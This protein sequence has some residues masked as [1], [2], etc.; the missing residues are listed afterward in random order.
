MWSPVLRRCLRQFYASIRGFQKN[1][2]VRVKTYSRIWLEALESRLA[3]AGGLSNNQQLLQ[4]YGQMPISFEANAGQTN[5]QV[6]YLAHGS[7]Y[8]VFL[9]PTGA[10]LSLEKDAAVTPIASPSYVKQGVADPATPLPSVTGVALAMTLVGANPGVSVTGLDQLS[11]TS[12]YFIGNGLSQWHTNIAN[13]G[14]VAY[15]DVYPGVNLVYYGNQQQLEYDFVVASGA[16]PSSIRLDFQGAD[17]VSLDDRGNLVLATASGDVVEHTP[18]VY[19]EVGG[20]RQ[21]IAGKFVLLGQGEV[22]FQVGT[23]D[24]NLPLTIDPVLSYSTYLGGS[25]GDTGESIAVDSSGNA[26]IAGYANSTNFPTTAGAFQTSLDS[27]SDAFV[28]KLNA[29]GTALIYSTYLGGS[30]ADVANGIAVDDSGNAY[31]AGYT[32]STNFPTTVGAFQ[33][34]LGGNNDAFVTKLDA[35][36]TALIYSTYLGGNNN[37]SAI[38]IAVDGSGNAYIGGLTSSTNFPT[39]VGAF[40]TSLGGSGN[41][42]AFVTKL[43]ATGAALIY[44][45]Y[46]GGSG[47]DAAYGIAVDSSGNSYVAGSTASTNFPTT[48][49]A[50]QTSLGGNNDAFVTKLDASGTA[51]IYSTYLGG[52]NNDVA[53][54]IAVDGSGNAFVT[55]Y[56]ESTNFPTT[57]GAFQTSLGG[58][59]NYNA[60][61]TKLDATG[62]ALSYSTY[63]GGSGNDGAYGIAVDS[64]GN[65]YIAG[66]VGS[67]N[68]PT[69]TGAFQTS[70]GGSSNVNAFVTKLN[71]TGTAL[72]YSTYLGGNGNDGAYGIAVDSSGNSYVTGEAGSAKF[73]ITTGAYQTMGANDAFVAKFSFAPVATQLA[74]GNLGSTGVTAGGTVTFTVTA[75][76]SNNNPVPGYTGTITLTSTDNNALYNGAALPAT[77][78]F[79]ASD[80]GSHTFTVTLQTD[81][82]RTITLTDVANNSLTVV[83]NP[84]T[85]SGAEA[86]SKFALNVLGGNTVLADNSFLLT[87]QA[88]DAFGNPVSGLN[89]PAS[90]TATASPADPQGNFPISAP[91]NSSGFAFLLGTLQTT[92]SYNLTAGGASTNVTVAPAAANYFTV[93]AP[94]SATTGTP[95]NVIVKAFDRFGNP[96]T[97]YTGTVNV[98]STDPADLNLLSA[99][100]TFVAAD[101]GVHTF[102]VMLNSSTLGRA[103]TTIIVRDTTATAPPIS[104]FSAPVAL[105]GLVV[106][107]TPQPTATGFTVTFSK[108]ITPADL[109]L[110]GLNTTT[111]PDV[112][113]V[114]ANPLN[115]SIPG[116]LFIDPANPNTIVFKAT[117]AF[118]EAL[119]LSNGN[120][121]NGDKDSVALPDDTYTVTLVSGS[122]SNGFVDALNSHLDGLGNGTAANYATTF[123]TTF[124]DDAHANANPVEV[125][126]IPDFARGPDGST[127]I[128]VPNNKTVPG[129][130][131]IL[132]NAASVQ[133]ATFTLTYNPTIFT[134]TGGG[135]GDAPAGSTFTMGAI[136]SIDSTHSAVSFTYHNATAHSGTVVLGDILAT[137]PNSAAVI[138]KTK[139]LLALSGITV[140]GGA[141]VQAANA[142]HVDAYLGD[143]HV[144]ALP[145]IDASDALDAEKVASGAATGFSAYTLL[146]PAIIGN[147]GQNISVDAA[148]VTNLFSKT[149]HLPVPRIP[150]IPAAVTTVSVSGADPTLSLV[151][152]VQAN[153]IVS[154]AVMLD[155]PH[156]AGSTGMTEAHLALTYDPSVLS[157]SEADITLGSIP[158]AGWRITSE[159]DAATGQIGINI[160]NLAG[161]PITPTQA[162][163]LVNIAFHVVPGAAPGGTSVQL[164]SQATPNG[165]RFVTE[166]DDDQGPLTLSPGVDRVDVAVGWKRR[167]RVR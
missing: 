42:N 76:D 18:V 72:S 86:F 49:G 106:V 66:F 149:A 59:G 46:L 73:P 102:S 119:D 151:G 144:T 131:I 20:S 27:T 44:S 40:Q 70:L 11:G 161:T 36:G 43:N 2:P 118:L 52:N 64:S 61:V 103:G 84:I 123:T 79:V 147:V 96:A 48:T 133:D 85:V 15:Q 153:G 9:T 100:Y 17:S 110:Y 165:Q 105:Q 75:E 24:S 98:T 128:T 21:A 14:Q 54:T 138:Y 126:A 141:T 7:G 4:S 164:V 13:Y 65:T 39:A 53:N 120:A 94:A 159:V 150:N 122:G 67:T 80:N 63:L 145:A 104:G 32:A 146:D 68:F 117:N 25:G 121:G 81:G 134:P 129:I 35:S 22:G 19:Q 152:A 82:S 37:D 125:L 71:A 95:F 58:S 29:T 107:G 5:A 78:T 34:S 148:A 41:Y 101:N 8:A 108:P 10:V 92:G 156:P 93:T 23:Y 50:Y 135:T 89:V 47:A 16:D 160:L 163:S 26:Y 127:T 51:L 111:V 83:T 132:Y 109:N 142:I 88:T 90:I 1:G 56:T 124:Q 158:G 112:T 136:T 38:A 116:T 77:H 114:G 99:P 115:G 30:G 166:V 3:P 28:T 140:T 137:V 139:E 130:P 60:F 143:V 57:T 167:G 87:A 33:T 157:V 91:V 154:V 155:H 12:N 6:Q 113:M 97:G 69:T 45:T 62:T 55:G 162:G 74:I 31:I